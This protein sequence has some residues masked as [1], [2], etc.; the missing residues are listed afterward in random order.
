MTSSTRLNSTRGKEGAAMVAAVAGVLE[1]MEI[2]GE[3]KIIIEEEIAMEVAGDAKI[4]V[5]DHVPDQDAGQGQIRG[6]GH[7]TRGHGHATRGHDRVTGS[8]PVDGPN[9]AVT[10]E[11][12]IY[13]TEGIMMRVIIMKK[14]SVTAREETT[15]KKSNLKEIDF[16]WLVFVQFQLLATFSVL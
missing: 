5:L 15:E 4:A 10:P 14:Q 1:D 11:E 9:H 12:L 13:L 8:L 16:I 6:H 2:I 3:T 7:V